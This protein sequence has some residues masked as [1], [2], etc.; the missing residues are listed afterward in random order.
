MAFRPVLLLGLGSTGAKIVSALKKHIDAEGD[1]YAK[2]FIR[3]LRITSEVN[4]EKGVDS[5][6][7]GLSL[8]VPKLSAPQAVNGLRELTGANQEI[9]R[10]HV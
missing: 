1:F 5:S 3:Y 9:G 7:P 2:H 10:A 6:I 8:A 4:P